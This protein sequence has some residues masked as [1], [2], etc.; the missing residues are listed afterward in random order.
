MD[1]LCGKGATD[2]EKKNR[3]KA[4]CQELWPHFEFIHRTADA[5][6]IAEYGRRT[7]GNNE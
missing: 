4:K 7:H 5:A 1:C 6:L 3:A 2:T